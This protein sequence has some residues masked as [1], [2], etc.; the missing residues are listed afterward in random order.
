VPSSRVRLVTSHSGSASFGTAH[1]RTDERPRSSLAPSFTLLFAGMIVGVIVGLVALF[2]NVLARRAATTAA[3][4]AARPR[5]AAALVP[6]A[7]P[8]PAPAAAPSATPITS[9]IE[10]DETLVTVLPVADGE[11]VVLDGRVVTTAEPTRVKCGKH[12]VRIG[13]GTKRKVS[14]PCGGALTLN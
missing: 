7:A 2:P 10:A 4:A 1:T 14:F 9:A 11:R 13:S 5:A 3:E 8:L 6:A 12:T